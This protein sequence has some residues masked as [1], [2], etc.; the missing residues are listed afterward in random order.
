MRDTGR[1]EKATERDKAFARKEWW[2]FLGNGQEA[3]VIR[4]VILRALS[5]GT[6][7]E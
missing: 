5:K 2:K 7:H 6:D 1:L 3:D 4:N